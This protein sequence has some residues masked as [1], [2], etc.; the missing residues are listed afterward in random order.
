[1]QYNRCVLKLLQFAYVIICAQQDLLAGRWYEVID[2]LARDKVGQALRDGI[3][4]L[5]FGPSSQEFPFPN[6]RPTKSETRPDRIKS[7]L[8]LDESLPHRPATMSR[9]DHDSS[10]GKSNDPST[11]IGAPFGE[12]PVQ[13][14]KYLDYKPAMRLVDLETLP[15]IQ[16]GAQSP[17]TPSSP[18]GH[19]IVAG[20]H[21]SQTARPGRVLAFQKEHS[22]HLFPGMPASSL[23]LRLGHSPSSSLLHENNRPSSSSS[24]SSR[25]P[26]L[27]NNLAELRAILDTQ[28]AEDGQLSMGEPPWTESDLT[29]NPVAY[30]KKKKVSDSSLFAILD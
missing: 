20:I 2:K 10:F 30:P 7:P 13:E 21:S 5:S 8:R 1:M 12:P 9:L 15:S 14:Q 6:P 17:R 23:F 24:S 29:P 26:T 16:F 22:D 28:R 4:H 19:V 27:S 11:V 25:S 3:K 18:P